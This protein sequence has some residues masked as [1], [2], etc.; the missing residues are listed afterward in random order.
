[1]RFAARPTFVHP[2]NLPDPATQAPTPLSAPDPWS[3]PDTAAASLDNPAGSTKN[4][5][6][7]GQG[8]GQRYEA[9]IRFLSLL[10]EKHRRSTDSNGL[11]ACE[12][13]TSKRS[14][15]SRAVAIG[16]EEGAWFHVFGAASLCRSFDIDSQKIEQVIARLNNLLK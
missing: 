4:R 10:V 9:E 13:V 3:F 1:M 7:Q 14:D 6:G 2:P 16:D 11:K 8:A 12:F 5:S 15:A